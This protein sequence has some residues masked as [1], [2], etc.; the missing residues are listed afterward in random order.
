MLP[1]DHRGG[2]VTLRLPDGPLASLTWVINAALAGGLPGFETALRR[3]EGCR[4]EGVFAEPPGETTDLRG[5]ALLWWELTGTELGDDPYVAGMMFAGSVVLPRD[6]LLDIYMRMR[7]LNRS[8]LRRLEQEATSLGDAP[9]AT[10]ERSALLTALDAAGILT[11]E[12]EVRRRLEVANLPL[13]LEYH[14]AAT[15]LLHYPP[16][17]ERRA[18]IPG[19]R[20]GPVVGAPVSIDWFR[21]GVV[22]R[23]GLTPFDWLAYCES[24]FADRDELHGDEGEYLVHHGGPGIASGGAGTPPARPRCSAWRQGT[25]IAQKRPP[26]P[27][28]APAS[29]PHPARNRW[30]GLCGLG[31]AGPP[32]VEAQAN[33]GRRRVSATLL[34]LVRHANLCRSNNRLRG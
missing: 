34:G 24:V 8:P 28:A 22:P 32:T 16:S 11:D 12:E 25:E 31:L 17:P 14:L 1:L 18:R 33:A 3:G 5:A 13:L 10:A 26:P 20:P 6:T 9:N 2:T 23:E 21:L 30:T 7:D 19:A 27:G 29:H 15:W 4:S